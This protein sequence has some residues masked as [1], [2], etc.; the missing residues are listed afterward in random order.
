MGELCAASSTFFLLSFVLICRQF[1][2]IS[3]CSFT[4]V[5][6]FIFDLYTFETFPSAH[7]SGPIKSKYNNKHCL[8][9][10][11]KHVINPIRCGKYNFP[12][13]NY[14][15]SSELS[16]TLKIHRISLYCVYLYCVKLNISRKHVTPKP[17]LSIYV[18]TQIYNTFR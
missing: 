8:I 5:N 9:L 10:T 6:S 14:K 18:Y 1:Y 16:T 12:K 2:I 7:F 4:K 15:Y 13:L 11:L 3:T 17:I